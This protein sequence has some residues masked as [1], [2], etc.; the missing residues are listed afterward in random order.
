MPRIIVTSDLSPLSA[1]APV[2]LDEQLQSV[3]L[4]TAHA[5]TQLIERLAWAVSDAENAARERPAH[6]LQPDRELRRRRSATRPRATRSR[7]S[8]R[9]S[10]PRQSTSHSTR[11]DNQHKA[12]QQATD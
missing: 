2:W 4:S 5:A 7:G 12:D 1:D 6:R 8:T 10:R 9:G 3:H 11:Y